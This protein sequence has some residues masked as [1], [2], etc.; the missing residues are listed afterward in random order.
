MK[1]VLLLKEKRF[2]VSFLDDKKF[3]RI[4]ELQ[5]FFRLSSGFAPHYVR[6]RFTTKKLQI[7]FNLI[8]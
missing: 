8:T 5:T 2:C 7:N 4:K 6:F 1:T 3:R